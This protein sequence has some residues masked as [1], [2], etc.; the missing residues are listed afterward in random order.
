MVAGVKG[1]EFLGEGEVAVS[2]STLGEL[3][4]IS[5]KERRVLRTVK[6]SK[7]I[8]SISKI[9]HEHALLLAEGDGSISRIDLEAQPALLQKVATL[10]DTRLT[11]VAAVSNSVAL[12]SGAERGNKTN[13]TVWVLEGSKTREIYSCPMVRALFAE[14]SRCLFGAI[15]VA[16][17]DAAE[18]HT[19]II[20]TRAPFNDTKEL[21]TIPEFVQ[22]IVKKS[23]DLYVRKQSFSL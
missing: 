19:K 22:V 18:A 1:V 12:I 5:L 15:D 7:K 20:E 14:E 8:E 4:V 13:S 9:P 11:S 2:S 17:E 3:F 23:K 16:D 21:A 10:E 6:V